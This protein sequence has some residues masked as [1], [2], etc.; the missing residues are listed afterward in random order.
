MKHYPNRKAQVNSLE[1][2]KGKNLLLKFPSSTDLEKPFRYTV[3]PHF[4]L[5]K[6]C[7]DSKNSLETVG[8]ERTAKKYE[9]TENNARYGTTFKIFIKDVFLAFVVSFKR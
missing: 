5:G 6:F 7:R 9:S 4:R 1:S 8:I 2:Q 3:K